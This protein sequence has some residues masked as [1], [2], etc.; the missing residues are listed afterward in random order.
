MGQVSEGEKIG[1]AQWVKDR[2]FN[3]THGKG[4]HFNKT[5]IMVKG[6]FS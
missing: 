4:T 2:H 3:K 5:I 6:H 1:Y